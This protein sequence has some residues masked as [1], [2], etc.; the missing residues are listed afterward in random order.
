MRHVITDRGGEEEEKESILV[1]VVPL[2][3]CGEVR[4]LVLEQQF[5]SD[6]KFLSS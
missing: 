3:Q 1:L 4:V 2:K 6:S 5:F